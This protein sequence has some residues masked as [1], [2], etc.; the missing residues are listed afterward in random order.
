MKS[1]AILNKNRE[2][3]NT[4]LGKRCFI[5]G[6]GPSVKDQNIL[7][8]KNEVK[9]CVNQFYKHPHF[10][11]IPPDYWVQA[12]PLIWQKKED[13]LL[14]LL[15]SIESNKIIT[16]LFF[17]LQGMFQTKG[18]N[19]LNVYYY[20]YD[21]LR[22]YV[23]DEIDFCRE[24]PPYG[25]NVLLVCL[26]L[27]FYLGCNPI[28]IVGAEHSWW[29]WEKEKYHNR[30]TP[31]FYNSRSMPASD[32]FS[33]EQIQ[34]TIFVQKFQ[35]LELKKYAV[36]NGYSIFNATVG[37]EL[38]VFERVSFEDLFP[39]LSGEEAI[40]RPISNIP[41]IS[42]VLCS[43]ALDLIQKKEFASALVLI[44]EAIR[45]NIN[46]NE[47][48]LGLH[49]LRSICLS[50]LGHNREAIKEARQDFICNPDNRENAGRLLQAMDDPFP[51]RF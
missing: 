23:N 35:Y 34:A 46:K 45:Q 8:L 15:N 44:D 29:S 37:G 27:A 5:I 9:L 21:Y 4:H 31:H 10:K 1:N 32:R 13:Y 50:G 49:Y 7:L 40:D 16:K 51:T 3:K 47:K 42:K 39:Y 33:Y 48:I 20:K 24:I 14:P 25:Q 17:P 41:G 6:N 22:R 26:M 43:N 2:L 11:Q 36:R 12:D 19:F 28:Y 38:D 18:S 30:Q